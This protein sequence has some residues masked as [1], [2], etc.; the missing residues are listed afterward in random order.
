METGRLKCYNTIMFGYIM[1]LI[2]ELKV[3][4]HE[5]LKAYYCGLC[6]TLKAKYHRTTI[7]NYDCTFIYLLGESLREGTEDVGVCN[8]GLHPIQKRVAVRSDAA[9]YAADIN[10]LM[11]YAKV[12]DDV[13]DGSVW[14]KL[15][16]P[17][18]GGLYKKATE[19][20][21]DISEKMRQMTQQ[22]TALE[23]QECADTD[24]VADTYAQLFGSVLM[25]LDVM[26]SHILYDL[27]YALGRWVY[28][29]D[30]YD[31][32]RWDIKNG[33]YNVFVLKYGITERIKDDQKKEAERNFFYTLATAADALSRLELKKN[34]PI[35]EN[36]I[37][38][39]LR[40]Q[41]EN[42]LERAMD[43][44]I[45]SARRKRERVGRGN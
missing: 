5:L 14:A 25:E 6:R 28:L 34:R 39:G 38:L 43:E 24:A 2:G 29:I 3:C 7:L 8:C 12:A 41:T 18:Y 40:Q 11:G 15:R 4:E 23:R 20:Q 22:L 36:I 44:P 30:A 13:R 17:S 32:I 9:G 45:R 37:R 42:V 16:K 27:G 31:D 1:P 26:Q 35:L 10:A 19:A 21:P 33:D